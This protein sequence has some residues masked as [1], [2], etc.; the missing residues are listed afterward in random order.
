M[1]D[2]PSKLILSG[3]ESTIDA[4][5]E[6]YSIGLGLAI[7]LRQAGLVFEPTRP[8][9]DT[10][11]LLIREPE[12]KTPHWPVGWPISETRKK[13]APSLFVKF[14]VQA[15]ETPLIDL[16]DAIELRSKIAFLY[17]KAAISAEE[18][19]MKTTK[20]TFSRP[21]KK[22]TFDIVIGKVLTQSKPKLKS[23]IK[24]DEVGKP[25]LWITPR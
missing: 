20:V 25:F 9:G 4:E 16:L 19:D 2:E 6:G 5:L 22:T 24:I 15:V 1:I 17:D 18:I 10:I 23:D 21:G 12:D 8:Q 14:P 11:Q 3:S 7:A 13:V